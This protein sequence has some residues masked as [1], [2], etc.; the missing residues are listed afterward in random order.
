MAVESLDRQDLIG[1]PRAATNSAPHRCQDLEKATN[2]IESGAGS[3]NRRLHH[4]RHHLRIRIDAP[5][6]EV[7]IFRNFKR[8]SQ[9]LCNEFLLASSRPASVPREKRALVNADRENRRRGPNC[10]FCRMRSALLRRL[11][12]SPWRSQKCHEKPSRSN[13]MTLKIH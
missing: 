12:G 6:R 5:N 7:W 2:P 3:G 9:S 11:L 8:G 4:L 13:P 1:P 10:H